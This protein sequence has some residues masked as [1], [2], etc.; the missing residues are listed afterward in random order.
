MKNISSPVTGHPDTSNEYLYSYVDKEFRI[1]KAN[2]LFLQKF[3]LLSDDYI[4]KPFR[5]VISLIEYKKILQAGK[6]CLKDPGTV[7]CEPQH[8]PRVV[9]G[10]HD[11]R[12][13]RGAW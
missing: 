5:E 7:I 9:A 6:A 3:E 10:L 8:S 2:S 11:R 4:G 13:H 12:C 1:V